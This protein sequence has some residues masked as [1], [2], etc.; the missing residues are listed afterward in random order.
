MKKTSVYIAVCLAVALLASCN[1]NDEP[2]ATGS[3]RFQFSHVV[4]NE[5][6]RLN[7][8]EYTN[9][10]GEPFRAKMFKYYVSNIRFRRAD[11]TEYAEP[12]SYHLIDEAAAASKTVTVANVPTGDYIA[13]RF[14]LGVD[15]VRNFSGAQTGALDPMNGMLWDWNTGY[16]FT[17]FEG[18]S[19]ASPERD[20]AIVYHI[21]GFKNPNNIRTVSP[22]LNGKLAVAGNRVTSLNYRVDVAQMFAAPTRI[23]F[24]KTPTLMSGP[25]TTQVA[26]NC[27]NMFL[28]TSITA[29]E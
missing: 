14:I 2:A 8:T 12:E 10:A 19:E 18:T 20:K 17:K 27:A 1:N 11:G 9:A 7:S 5:P 4:G 3:V 23:E 29:A 24:A 26:D 6:L 28:V 16:I 13:V 25:R 15:S 22:P 21:G